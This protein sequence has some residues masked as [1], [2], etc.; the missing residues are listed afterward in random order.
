M[1][2]IYVQYA[3]SDRVGGVQMTEWVTGWLVL[4]G[5]VTAPWSSEC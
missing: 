3:G 1:I 2:K 5:G 4:P